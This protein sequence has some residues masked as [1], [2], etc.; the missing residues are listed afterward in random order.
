ME[1]FVNEFVN[2]QRYVPY[3]RVEKSKVYSFI[4]GLSLV[5]KENI[6]FEIIQQ[7]MK[8]LERPS[9]AT[10]CLNKYPN[11]V[12]V[13]K[14]K[15]IEKIDR[16]SINVGNDLNPHLLEKEQEVI[17]IKITTGKVQPIAMGQRVSKLL[18]ED[19]IVTCKHVAGSFY[20]EWH[21]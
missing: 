8:Q 12:E 16:G 19:G 6:V 2:L 15:K 18:V 10:I 4:I 11:W 1:E 17:L 7:W 9:C 14:I 13:G 3:L 20:C 5:Y 21:S